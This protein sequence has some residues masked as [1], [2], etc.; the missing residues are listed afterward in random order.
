MGVI[1]QNMITAKYSGITITSKSSTDPNTVII[2]AVYG[3]GAAHVIKEITPDHYET[4]KKPY[5][6]LGKTISKQDW[7]LKRIKGQTVKDNVQESEREKQKINTHLLKDLTNTAIKLEEFFG[8]PQII[9]WAMDKADIYIIGS[10]AVN[11]NTAEKTKKS[12]QQKINSFKNQMLLKG[13]GVNGDITN[14]IIVT[15]INYNDLE[16]ITH[17][18][19]LVTAMTDQEMIGAM[20]IARGIITNAGS[21][22]CHAAVISK[23]L[24]KPCIVGTRFATEQLLDGEKIQMNAKTGEIYAIASLDVIDIHPEEDDFLDEKEQRTKQLWE[25]QREL[26]EK[27][28]VILNKNKK[29]KKKTT[30][31]P[32]HIIFNEPIEEKNEIKKQETKEKYVDENGNINIKNLNHIDIEKVKQIVIPINLIFSSED[33]AK[34]KSEFSG[35]VCMVAKEKIKKV[36][37]NIKD[38]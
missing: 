2:E 4:Q 17:E 31:A 23:D 34:L 33:I 6:T 22:L 36:L 10:E 35:S 28:A 7:Q 14:G 20:K 24:D 25:E 12:P 37:K 15:V 13:V 38:F 19:I 5:Q 11:P 18:S 1:I 32:K 26:R 29:E 27:G 16:K 9:E 30:S 21:S 3:F 8:T